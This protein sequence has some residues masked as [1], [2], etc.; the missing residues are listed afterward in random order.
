MIETIDRES[1]KKTI[2]Q[3]TKRDRLGCWIWMGAKDGNG[4]GR[5]Y[6]RKK[7]IPAHRLSF[8]IFVKDIPSG[9]FA[10]HKC[11]VALCV[12]PNHLFS[13][14]PKDNAVDAFKK[15]RIKVPSI[16]GSDHPFSAANNRPP[17]TKLNKQQVIE[18]RKKY[19]ETNVTQKQLAIEY[20]VSENGIWSVIHKQS[21]KNI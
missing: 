13:G 17:W 21:W 10:C 12:N 11:D 15:G 5:Y 9:H 18:I 8:E 19:S 6:H 7:W 4:Y 14:T 2:L 16:K 3:K 20:R 1:A